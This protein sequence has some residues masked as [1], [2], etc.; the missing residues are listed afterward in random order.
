[1][2]KAVLL[3]M[4]NTLLVNPDMAFAKA[5]LEQFD[6]HMYDRLQVENVSQAFRQVIRHMSQSRDGDETNTALTIRTLHEATSHPHEHIEK[7]LHVFYA[8][9][10]PALQKYISPVVGASE[11]IQK[12]VNRGYKVVIATNPLYPETAIKQRMTWA[13]LP[14]DDDLYALVTS[15]DNMH[16]SKPNPAYYAEM[17]GRIG[18]EPNETLMVGDS[19]R[20]DITPA[21]NI[22]IHTYH[23]HENSL[24]DFQD[25]FKMLIESIPPITLHPSMIAPQLRGNLGALYG[26]LDNIQPETWHLQPHEDEWSI[27]QILH[28]LVTAENSNLRPQ[29]KRILQENNPFITSPKPPTTQDNPCADDGFTILQ[30]FKISR[31][32]TLEFL[33]TIKES[34]WLRPAQHSTVGQTTLLEIAYLMVQHDRLRLNQLRHTIARYRG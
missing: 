11:L 2:I 19:L 27:I 6:Q 1:M 5:F 33:Q 30:D 13:Q 20:N 25:N 34:D 31:L 10:Y 24:Q 9:K 22:G 26:L 28:H 3:D 12:L 14:M 7:A 16:F 17:L 32:K 4:D 23:I 18:V 8:E 29:L 15:A 21:K